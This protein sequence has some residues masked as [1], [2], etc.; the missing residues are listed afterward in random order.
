MVDEDADSQI[1]RTRHIKTAHYILRAQDLSGYRRPHAIFEQGSGYKL[2]NQP[3][4]MPMLTR[5]AQTGVGRGRSIVRW[6]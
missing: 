3:Q 5:E 1:E 4:A 2:N 6:C